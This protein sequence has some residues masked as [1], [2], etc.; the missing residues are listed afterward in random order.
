MAAAP[1]PSVATDNGVGTTTTRLGNAGSYVTTRVFVPDK[2]TAMSV[3]WHH[4]F[5]LLDR[6]KDGVLS[7]DELLHEIAHGTNAEVSQSDR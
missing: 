4:L 6:D 3:K 1:G 7:R 5:D 2:E